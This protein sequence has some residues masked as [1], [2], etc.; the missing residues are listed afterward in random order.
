MVCSALGAGGPQAELL[1]EFAPLDQVVLS[2]ARS[3]DVHGVQNHKMRTPLLR[4]FHMVGSG[5]DDKDPWEKLLIPKTCDG[6]PAV[7]GGSKMTYR[8]YLQDTAFAV[9]LEVPEDRADTIA[10][11]LQNPVWGIHLGRKTC[12][13]TDYVFRGSFTSVQDAE[14][15]ASEIAHEKNRTEDF[16][17]FGCHSDKEDSGEV[18]TLNDVPV[19][20]GEDKRYRDRRVVVVYGE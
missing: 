12:V 5:Y 7:G 2:F 17:V 16:R 1:A 20:F 13:P 4:D 19:Q 10:E 15:Q 6:K 8:Y 14:N 18:L 11:A 9:M 3:K